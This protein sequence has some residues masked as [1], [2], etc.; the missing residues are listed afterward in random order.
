MRQTPAR[1]NRAWLTILGLVLLLAGLAAV[2]IGTGLLTPLAQAL[3]LGLSSPAPADSVVGASAA[4]AFALTW[5]VAITAL[6]AIIV[7]L[8]GLA[9]L[10]AQI[11]RTNA[12]KPF[13]LH[14]DA[15]T[16]LTR[17]DPSVLTDAVETQVKLLPGVHHASAVLR[18]TAAHPDL[19]LRVTVSDRTDLPR[20]LATLQ[21]RVAADLATALD[22]RLQRLGVQLEIDSAKTHTNQITI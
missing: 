22:T 8:L 9:W 16:G 1:L 14:D 11:P 10:V 15:R 3:G 7:A 20:L 19:T 13:R 6:A 12:A 4:S 17:A 2:V 18:G 21:D 5:V